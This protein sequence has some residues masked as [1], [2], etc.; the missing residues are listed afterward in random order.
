MRIVV[1]PSPP[2]G[3]AY[4]PSPRMGR[5]WGW[6]PITEGHCNRCVRQDSPDRSGNQVSMRSYKG[7]L[8][9]GL[10]I[11]LL[12][13]CLTT[14]AMAA[15]T[16]EQLNAALVKAVNNSDAAE[17]KALLDRGADPN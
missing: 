6:G 8:H 7:Y 16:R 3:S 11:T 17:I 5:G 15:Q 9:I 1:H 12:F 13:A 4:P 10:L 2:R 14:V